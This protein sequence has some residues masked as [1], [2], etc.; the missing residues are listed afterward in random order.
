[1]IIIFAICCDRLMVALMRDLVFVPR[2]SSWCHYN[3][4]LLRDCY[5]GLLKAMR[6]EFLRWSKAKVAWFL[7]DI[8]VFSSSLSRCVSEVLQ[9][10][11]CADEFQCGKL[12]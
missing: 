12:I 9:V 6:V 4:E 3:E 2:F 10:I 1:M 7:Q 11:S 5:R 8:F